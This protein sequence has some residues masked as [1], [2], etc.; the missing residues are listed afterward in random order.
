MRDAWLVL[1]KTA[2][3]VKNKG[4]LRNSHGP[5][6]TRR[7]GAW[8]K[9]DSNRR[10]GEIQTAVT[11]CRQRGKLGERERLHCLYHLSDCLVNLNYAKVKK[12]F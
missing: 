8:T 7:R 11:R 5:E 10:G 2:V 12:L 6:E 3:A 4:S 9:D 1:L